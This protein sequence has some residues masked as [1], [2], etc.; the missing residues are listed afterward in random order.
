MKICGMLA[1]AVAV[2][3]GSAQA[4]TVVVNSFAAN[5]TTLGVWGVN[6]QVG[7]AT[8]GVTLAPA[9]GSLPPGAAVLTTTNTNADKIVV[10][11]ANDYGV[12]RDVISNINLS[13]DYYKTAD[14]GADAAAAPAMKLVFTDG[15]NSTTLVYEPYWNNGVGTVASGTW[16]NTGTIDATHGV[17]WT[18]GGFG[19]ANGAG[20]PPLHTLSDWETTFDSGFLAS[21]LVE[22]QMGMGSYNPNQVGY[23]DAVTVNGTALANTTYNF[24]AAVVPLPSAAGMGFVALGVAALGMGVRKKLRVV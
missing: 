13:Y 22:V 10:G 17:F 19:Q 2:A 20:G 7:S 8:A 3:A 23:F 9:G 6:A 1:L 18:T 15:M 21:H 14:G 11:V 24:E 5:D 12:A 16:F 4:S